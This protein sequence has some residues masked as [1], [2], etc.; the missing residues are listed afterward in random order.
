MIGAAGVE[1]GLTN[2]TS[3][4]GSEIV[5][6][7]EGASAVAA[8]DCFGLPL[9]LAPHNGSVGNGFVMTLNAGIERVTALEFNG[10]DVTLGVIV[11]ALGLG[12]D[13]GAVTG[14]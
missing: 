13:A 11:R 9:S 1:G 4:V 7:T 8:K 14:N 6:Y 10:D 2:R 12:I 3:V 5:D